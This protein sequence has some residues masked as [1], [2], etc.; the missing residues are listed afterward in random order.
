M[1]PTPGLP[2][3][4]IP[5]PTVTY[6]DLASAYLTHVYTCTLCEPNCTGIRNDG[7]TVLLRYDTVSTLCPEA[8]TLLA[9]I[10]KLVG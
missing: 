5:Q 4:P 8:V 9:A 6:R 2:Q 1:P 3:I 7:Q 10:S